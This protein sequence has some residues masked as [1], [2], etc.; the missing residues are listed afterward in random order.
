MNL[1]FRMD[2]AMAEAE[3][4][5]LMHDIRPMPV[6]SW[7]GAEE[8]PVFLDQARWLAGA[9]PTARLHVEP[10]RHH[11]DVIEPLVEAESALTRAILG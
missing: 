5:C 8:R 4:P 2:M 3:S 11:F 9:W 10:G 6:V 7:V 1:D